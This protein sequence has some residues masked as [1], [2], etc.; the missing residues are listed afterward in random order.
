[1]TSVIELRNQLRARSFL[2]ALG[3]AIA[4]LIANVIA[5]PSFASPGQWADDLGIFAPLALVAMAST[6]SIVSGG[7]DISIGPLMNFVSIVVVLELLPNTLGHP[8]FAIPIALGLGASIGAINGVLI[9]YFRYQ[10]VIATLCTFFVLGGANIALA[11]SPV[12]TTPNWTS[13][14][15]GSVGPIP[16]GLLTI[17]AVLAI[18]LLLQRTAFH[19]GLLAVGGD[20]AAAF[21]AGTRVAA[22][23]VIAYALGG[24]FAGIAGLALTG[25]IQS[26]D[27]TYGASYALVGLAAVA[28]GGTPIGGGRGGLLGSLAGAAVIYLLRNVLVATQV[29]TV[30]LQVVYGALLIVGVILSSL[31]AGSVRARGA[32]S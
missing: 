23:R 25:L 22:V 28:L 27:P 20:D 30:W 18:W 21:S 5:L 16:G 31:V 12:P 8:E 1:L 26:A 29:S 19:K 32:A 6:P 24:L 4:L 10:P 17:G 3:I 11:P 9:A 13:H 15:V 7:L 14:L 2:F